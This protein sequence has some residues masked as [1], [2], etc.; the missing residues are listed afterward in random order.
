MPWAS[1]AALE[2]GFSFR[3]CLKEAVRSGDLDPGWDRSW[4]GKVVG[5]LLGD[6]P[7]RPATPGPFAVCARGSACPPC[8]TGAKL[9]TVLPSPPHTPQEG[10]GPRSSPRGHE[11]W[12]VWSW[13]PSG[14]RN[15][16]GEGSAGP[17]GHESRRRDHI[18]LSSPRTLSAWSNSRAPLLCVSKKPQDTCP[19]GWRALPGWGGAGWGLSRCSAPGEGRWGVW[20]AMSGQGLPGPSEGSSVR[21]L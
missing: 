16:P 19:T 2:E 8:T 7:R 11:Q 4:G 12:P 3:K 15:W 10:C 13:V 1:E 18:L 6:E 14:G 20:G 9:H 5:M 17:A 21:G